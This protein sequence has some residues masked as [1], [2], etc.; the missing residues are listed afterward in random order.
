MAKKKSESNKIQK[1]VNNK[2]KTKKQQ[3]VKKVQGSNNQN[4]F[5]M[6]LLVLLGVAILCFI[7]I[8]LMK[9]FFVDRSYIKINMSTDKKLEYIKL[10]GQEELITTQKYVSDLNYTMRY[11]IENFTVF[12]YKGQ[13]IY[14]FKNDERILVVVELSGLPTSC[15]SGTLNMEYNNCYVKTDNYTEEYYISTN[16]RTYKVMI[17]SLNTSEYISGVR[18]RINY[19]LK[20]FEMVF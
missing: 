13:D 12:K 15:L 16:G 3:P 20:T 9:F 10:E 7:T 6:K 5:I 1:S 4:E 19:M 17:K 18:S 11:D 14:K 2:S 8:Y